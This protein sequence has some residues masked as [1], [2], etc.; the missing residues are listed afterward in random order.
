MT[1]DTKLIIKELYEILKANEMLDNVSLGALEPVESEMADKAVY[2]AVESIAMESERLNK[3]SSGYD[4]RM[5]VTLY[6]NYKE[7]SEDPLGVY[8]F[9][10]NV[11][12]CV[13]EDNTIWTVIV[14][15]NIV[16]VTY[17]NQQF[18]PR[19][20]ITMLFDIAYRLSCD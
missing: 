13:L 16:G 5:L 12:R 3:G 19:R 14:D 11:E 8:D 1:T 9:T 2:I 6:C 17:D 18:S 20:T 4:R 10:D 15:R 7:D